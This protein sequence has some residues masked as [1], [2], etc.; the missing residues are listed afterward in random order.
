MSNEINL[1]KVSDLPSNFVSSRNNFMLIYTKQ[2]VFSILASLTKRNQEQNWVYRQSFIG[3]SIYSFRLY[4]K[5]DDGWRCNCRVVLHV[6][7]KKHNNSQTPPDDDEILHVQI[8]FNKKLLRRDML[9]W[10]SISQIFLPLKNM[11]LCADIYNISMFTHT[12]THIS[13]TFLIFLIYI[14]TV[15]KCSNLFML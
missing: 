15:L 14:V 12:N 9:S 4:S 3:F 11:L 13:F 8:L 10:G 6:A 7:H 1:K 5:I 2:N